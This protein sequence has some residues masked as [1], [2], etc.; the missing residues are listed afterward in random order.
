MKKLLFILV[1]LPTIIYGQCPSWQKTT[2]PFNTKIGIQGELGSQNIETT[3]ILADGFEISMV[4]TH[5]VNWLE[6]YIAIGFNGPISEITSNLGGEI[7]FQALL[8]PIKDTN[9]Y[10]V[11]GILYRNGYR[12]ND[13]NPDNHYGQASATA[14][15]RQDIRF[16][17]KQSFS[18]EMKYRYDFITAY[19]YASAKVIIYLFKQTE[20]NNEYKK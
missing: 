20:Y 3:D 10:F 11:P 2:H 17:D 19:H 13:G 16:S 9:F 8:E 7:G 15:I 12:P 1:L 6:S 14:G 5:R 4:L 18:F